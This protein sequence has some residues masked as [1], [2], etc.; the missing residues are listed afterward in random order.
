[1]ALDQALSPGSISHW[2][3]DFRNHFIFQN[4]HFFSSFLFFKYLFIYLKERVREAEVDGEGGERR[5]NLQSVAH[6]SNLGLGQ[7][8]PEP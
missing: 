2:L 7:V 8:K 1:M 3:Y 4:L 6:S 5:E